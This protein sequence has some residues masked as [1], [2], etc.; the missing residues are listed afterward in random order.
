MISLIIPAYNEEL[1]VSK[2]IKEALDTLKKMNLKNFE[3]ILVDDG[4]IDNTND[5]AKKYGIKIIRNPINMGY[6]F[7]LKR[8]ITNARFETVVIMDADDTYP[9]NE[10]PKLYNE[11]LKGFDMVIGQRTGKFYE[12]SKLKSFLR[13]LLKFIVEFAAEK[14]IPDINSG[15]RVFKRDTIKKFF[16]Q[17]SDTFSFTTSSTLAYIMNKKFVSFIP[18]KYEKRIGNSKVNLLRDSLKTSLGIIKSITYYNPL[19]IFILFS[20]I[21]IC[22]SIIGFMSSILIGLA[23]GFY[24]GIG[25][26]L[27]SL[28]ILSIGLLADLLK[29]IMDKT[30]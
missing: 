24:L 18:I 23:S 30:S 2:T 5:K 1:I 21:C 20:I 26:L 13:K 19:R 25:G 17:L 27:L 10:I 28:I 12:E 9:V 16:P 14:K 4:C 15:L 29:Q 7:S 6:G 8:G 22:F 11:Y 3:I